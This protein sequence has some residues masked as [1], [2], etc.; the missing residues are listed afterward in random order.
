MGDSS[1]RPFKPP[2]IRYPFFMVVQTHDST[3]G[4]PVYQKDSSVLYTAIQRVPNPDYIAPYMDPGAPLW[5]RRMDTQWKM[6][7]RYTRWRSSRAQQRPGNVRMVDVAQRF[8]AL[9]SP[10]TGSEEES[11]YEDP[12]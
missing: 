7:D 10:V 12:V 2:R 8:E 9:E 3:V 4:V 6:E 11:S 1:S 5:H